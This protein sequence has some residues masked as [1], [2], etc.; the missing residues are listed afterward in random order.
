MWITIQHSCSLNSVPAG[1]NVSNTLQKTSFQQCEGI[2]H[3]EKITQLLKMF[4]EHACV[5]LRVWRQKEERVFVKIENK[6]S[7]MDAHISYIPHKLDTVKVLVYSEQQ[8]TMICLFRLFKR[9]M[10]PE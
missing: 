7:S 5:C 9:E 1:G 4:C 2:G 6:F 8:N 10:T 3:E